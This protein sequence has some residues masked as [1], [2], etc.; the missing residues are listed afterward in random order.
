MSMAD[1][2][3][4]GGAEPQGQQSAPPTQAQQAQS[5][6]QAEPQATTTAQADTTQQTQANP[7]QADTT[8]QTQANPAN[9]VSTTSSTDGSY[10]NQIGNGKANYGV[11]THFDPNIMQNVSKPLDPKAVGVVPNTTNPTTTNKADQEKQQPGQL[12][13]TNKVVSQVGDPR[14][15]NKDGVV[16]ATEKSIAR[17]K[18]KTGKKQSTDAQAA[19]ADNTQQPTTTA[20]SR[21]SKFKKVKSKNRATTEGIQYYSRFLKTMI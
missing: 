12:A 6:A 8:Q 11:A 5:T 17:K 15:L 20:E 16:D 19:A 21:M 3:E 10:N 2:L 18:R 7:A 14:D 1:E 4:K 13:N 9:N